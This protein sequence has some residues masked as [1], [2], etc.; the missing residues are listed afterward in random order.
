MALH[1]VIYMSLMG[2]KGLQ[3]VSLKSYSN[4]HYLHDE[5]LKTNLFSKI[6]DEEFFVNLFFVITV[7]LKN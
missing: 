4:A 7:M 3:E 6:T 1:T 5:L 2:K